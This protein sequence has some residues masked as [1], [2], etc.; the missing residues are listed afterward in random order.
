MILKLLQLITR[1]LAK[2]EKRGKNLDRTPFQTPF[3]LN[4]AVSGMHLFRCQFWNEM[5]V[6]L[7]SGVRFSDHVKIIAPR[8]LK[9][10][11]DS[12]ILNRV[13]LDASGGL[14]I[15]E[16]TMIDFERIRLTSSHRFEELSMAIHK[17]GMEFKPVR[18]GNDVWIGARVIILADVTIENHAN[19]GAGAVVT[20]NVPEFAIVGGNPAKVIRY[21]NVQEDTVSPL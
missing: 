20:K 17:Q 3:W 4:F 21:R 1:A 16:D 12:K 10:G 13:I 6:T 8:N 15:G 19:L 2:L 5:G 11:R 7:E 14:E 18:V 9:I